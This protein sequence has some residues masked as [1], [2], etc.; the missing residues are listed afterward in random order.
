MDVRIGEIEATIVDSGDD[1]AGEASVERIARRVMALIDQRDR[2]RRHAARDRAI[3]SPDA[4][5]VERYG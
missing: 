1:G 5:D 3:A 4:Q 2:T